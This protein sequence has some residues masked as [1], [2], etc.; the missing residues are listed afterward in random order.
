[1]QVVN[2]VLKELNEDLDVV[3]VIVVVVIKKLRVVKEMVL[4][5]FRTFANQLWK[6]RESQKQPQTICKLYNLI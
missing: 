4:D 2:E 5:M 3:M 1:M 6:V